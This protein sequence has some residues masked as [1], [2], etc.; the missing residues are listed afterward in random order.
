MYKFFELRKDLNADTIPPNKCCY[1][2]AKSLTV[3]DD[4]F[5]EHA[6]TDTFIVSCALCDPDSSH[7]L[8]TDSRLLESELLKRIEKDMRANNERNRRLRITAEI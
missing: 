6:L 2:K 3:Q 4:Y 8:T 5:G 7:L 1:A